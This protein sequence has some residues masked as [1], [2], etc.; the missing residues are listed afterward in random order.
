MAGVSGGADSVA[1]AY[2]LAWLA[3]RRRWKLI[4]AHLNHG[5]RGRA[6][7]EDEQWVRRLALRLGCPC[8]TASQPVAVEARRQGLSLEMAARAAR[9]DFFRKTVCATGAR[10]LFLAHTADDQAETVLLKLLRGAGT[11]GLGGMEPCVRVNGL[12]IV[13]PLLDVRR[14]V[15]RG[16]LR[17]YQLAWREDQSNQDPRFLRNRLRREVMPLLAA[18]FNP[19]ISEVLCRTAAVLREDNRWLDQGSRRLWRRCRAGPAGTALCLAALRRCPLAARRR[20]LRLWLVAVGG[21]ALEVD[22]DLVARVERWMERA[23][24]GNPLGLAGGLDLACRAGLLVLQGRETGRAAAFARRLVIPGTTLIPE[25]GWRVDVCP[26]RG[27]VAGAKARGNS[28]PFAAAIRQDAVGRHPLS[29]R[30]WR[31][32]DRIRPLGMAGSRKVQD[33]FTDRKV[34]RAERWR[35]P[36]LACRGVLVWIPGYQ[37]ARG[38]EIRRAREAAWHITVRRSS[39]SS[40]SRQESTPCSA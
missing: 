1:L 23:A 31:P 37:V 11:R 17:S 24:V 8:V 28:T 38:W 25:A 16:W 7:D 20:I 33:V 39:V 27:R 15:L 5:L 18:R 10:R 4:L 36:L 9:H 21:N 35:M 32:G 34:P 29:M 22:F 12:I 14:D 13:R 30:S 19:R 26:G 40:P 3:R 6:A 2:L